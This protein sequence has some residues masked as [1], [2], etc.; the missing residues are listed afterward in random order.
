MCDDR[1]HFV[2]L[3]KGNTIPYARLVL[4]FN[5]DGSSLLGQASHRWN[6]DKLDP[7][8]FVRSCAYVMDSSLGLGARACRRSGGAQCAGFGLEL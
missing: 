3:E 6:G 4:G 1:A 7:I 5:E 8:R 2:A